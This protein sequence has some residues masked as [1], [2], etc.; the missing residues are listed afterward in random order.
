MLNISE[1]SQ[2]DKLHTSII[3][4]QQSNNT[5]WKEEKCTFWSNT[6]QN[7]CI[8]F[9]SYEVQNWNQHWSTG[10]VGY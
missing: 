8:W 2:S 7:L 1:Q 5:T 10:T 9:S 3:I 4:Q 6:L